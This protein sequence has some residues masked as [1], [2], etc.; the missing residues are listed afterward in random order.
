MDIHQ[1][2]QED[3]PSLN[4]VTAFEGFTLLEFGTPWCGHCLA[5][6]P[7]IHQALAN[8]ETL[9]YIKIFDGK[10]KK[11]GRAFGVK[12]WPSL[13]LLEG[14]GEVARLI[15]P[16]QIKEVSEFLATLQKSER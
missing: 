10:G 12:L 3:A 1:D 9:N 4:E 16:T 13:I 11:L 7:V 5:A 2:Y 8:I 14:G 15:R 6:Q